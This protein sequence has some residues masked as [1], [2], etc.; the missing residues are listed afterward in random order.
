MIDVGYDAFDGPYCYKGTGILR[1]KAGLRD[2][3]ALEAFELE[4]TTLRADEPL[5]DGRFGPAHYRAVR[6]RII[7]PSTAIC[8]RTSIRGRA[9]TARSAHPR[10]ATP[11]AFQSIFR[12][13]WTP[14]SPSFVQ[15]PA[16]PSRIGPPSQ[17]RRRSSSAN[18]TPSIPFVRATAQSQLAFMHLIGLRAGHP[19]DFAGVDR[20]TFLP[21]MVASYDK[22][23]GPLAAELEHLLA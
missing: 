1:N 17:P 18:S 3:D 15:D 2:L 22:D 23:Y 21:A 14:Y 12:R 5:P 11:S 19:F 13:R 4:M 6:R 16:S 20:Q 8:F 10:V 7:A 9:V